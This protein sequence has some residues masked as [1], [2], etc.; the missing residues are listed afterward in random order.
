MGDV[1]VNSLRQLIDMVGDVMGQDLK[2]EALF[3]VLEGLSYLHNNTIVHGD[4]KS[5]NVLVSEVDNSYVFKL[6][7]FG[8]SHAQISTK[9]FSNFSSLNTGKRV[10][11]GTTSFEAPEV[12]QDKEKSRASDV[13]SFGMIMHQLLCHNY[14][15]PWE[16]V[17]KQCSQNTLASL[18]I[19]AV[20]RG[21][22]PKIHDDSSPYVRIMQLCWAQEEAER[23]S[24]VFLIEQIDDLEVEDQILFLKMHSLIMFFFYQA[25]A[26][27]ERD[28]SSPAFRPR[29]S[30]PTFY[31]GLNVQLL[32]LNV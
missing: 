12:F 11:P 25:E 2:H 31:V 15:H 14:S 30:G 29:R 19:E 9:I 21:H 32:G 17:F 4:L 1:C 6:T 16:S 26:E 27:K 3:Q 5:A 8:G 28:L 7:D 24:I 10:K 20:K 13:Y 23:P 18:I 22:R